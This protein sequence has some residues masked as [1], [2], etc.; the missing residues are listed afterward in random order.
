MIRIRVLLC[1]PSSYEPQTA[2]ALEPWSQSHLDSAA[3]VEWTTLRT[4]WSR[5]EQRVGL[6]TRHL[7]PI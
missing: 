2:W 7:T 6:R 5:S 1:L 3:A 4:L